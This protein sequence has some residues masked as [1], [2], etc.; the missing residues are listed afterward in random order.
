MIQRMAIDSGIS[1]HDIKNQI[2]NVGGLTYSERIRFLNELRSFIITIYN[3]ELPK[4]NL[5]NTKYLHYLIN[6]C[7]ECDDP[8]KFLYRAKGILVFI[9]DKMPVAK[10]GAQ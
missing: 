10:D 5:Q 6:K 2:D 8:D 1:L 9:I 7:L 3:I 4:P